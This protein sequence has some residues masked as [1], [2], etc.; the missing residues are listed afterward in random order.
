MRGK[1]F[2]SLLGVGRVCEW[3]GVVAYRELMYGSTTTRVLI[4]AVINYQ[5]MCSTTGRESKGEEM[6]ELLFPQSLNALVKMPLKEFCCYRS[7]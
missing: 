6:D 4:A 5:L 3:E 1:C 7:Q 2:C